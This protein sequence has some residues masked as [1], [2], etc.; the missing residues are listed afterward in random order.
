[1]AAYA[2][3]DDCVH[4]PDETGAHRE[5]LESSE[6]RFHGTQVVDD[7]FHVGTERL[8]TG[9]GLQDLGER[10]LGTLEPGRGDSFPA[11]IRSDKELGIRKES[12]CPGEAPQSGLGVGEPQR[13]S[14]EVPS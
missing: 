6:T 5:R 7:L 2:G 8:V 4:L 3:E 10:R 14:L 12:C 1:M 13:L 11:R 9:F